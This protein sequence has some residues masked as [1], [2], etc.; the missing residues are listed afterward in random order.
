MSW[1]RRLFLWSILAALAVPTAAVADEPLVVF[2]VRHAEKVDS[3]ED[4]ALSEAGRERAALLARVLR[5]AHL[6]RVH[7]SDYHRTRDT[8][9]PV[10][11]LARA[12]VELYDPHNLPALVEKLKLVGGRHLV[13][14]HSNTTPDVVKLLG[15]DPG[16]PIEEADEYDRLY[17][18]TVGGGKEASTVLIRYGRAPGVATDAGN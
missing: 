14:G 18:V 5:D 16:T 7:S 9:A 12:E 1:S 6:E 8:A 3:S 4:P 2:L 17:V 11:E 13:V 10:A 15:G